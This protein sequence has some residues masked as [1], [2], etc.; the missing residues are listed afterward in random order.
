MITSGQ[1]I[2]D[3]RTSLV[4][5]FLGSFGLKCPS[6]HNPA[7]YRKDCINQNL[8]GYV[9][10]F[11]VL[12]MEVSSGDYGEEI[13]AKLVVS[14]SQG[15]CQVFEETHKRMLKDLCTC[16]EIPC[17]CV[18]RRSP[19][20]GYDVD[21]VTSTTSTFIPV[22]GDGSLQKPSGENLVEINGNGSANGHAGADTSLLPPSEDS[23]SVVAVTAE[24]HSFATTCLTQFRVL[25]IRTFKSIIRDTVKKFA[26]S[27]KFSCTVYCP[28]SSLIHLNFFFCRH[29]PDFGCSLM[30]SLDCLSACCTC[31][32][33]KMVARFFSMPAVC[34]SPCSS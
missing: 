11:S 19:R 21:T 4:V 6:Y 34:S 14:V 12:V 17:R 28:Y 26:F 30:S 24:Y 13:I 3:G 9:M 10:Q 29:L 16:R 7:D 8:K 25:F 5:P 20:R 23:N 33:E 27:S 31:E 18:A 1:C 32:L 2:Y 22:L 15:A